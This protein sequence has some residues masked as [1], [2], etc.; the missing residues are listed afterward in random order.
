LR[1]VFAQ[2]H[3]I[4]IRGQQ[5]AEAHL[6]RIDEKVLEKGSLVGRLQRPATDQAIDLRVAMDIGLNLH[7]AIRRLAVR[8]SEFQRLLHGFLLQHPYVKH[9]NKHAVIALPQ[10]SLNTHEWLRNVS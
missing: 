7:D 8:I 6:K 2:I 5:L 4:A 10:N 9:P 1:C 3:F